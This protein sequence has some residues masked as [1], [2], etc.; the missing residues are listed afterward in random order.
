MAHCRIIGGAGQRG[1]LPSKPEAR[2]PAETLNSNTRRCPA[3]A[4]IQAAFG[5]GLAHR[6][7]RPQRLHRSAAVHQEQALKLVNLG[8]Q[9]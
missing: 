6:T 5:G 8:R 9:R 1:Q 4:A 7:A 2:R 3:T